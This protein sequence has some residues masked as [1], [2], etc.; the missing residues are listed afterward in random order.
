MTFTAAPPRA[1]LHKFVVALL[2]GGLGRLFVLNAPLL[3][4][5][6][7]LR[8]D[9]AVA[10]FSALA[11]GPWFGAVSSL[12]ATAGT[13]SPI[14]TAIWAVEPLFVVPVVG[15]G[16][17]PV[18]AVAGYWLTVGVTVSSGLLQLPAVGV[19]FAL[20]VARQ[21]VNG[22]LSAVL[23]QAALAFDGVRQLFGAP[24]IGGPSAPL[25]TQIARAL[26]PVST[27]PV[28][29][30]GLGLGRMYA[31]QLVLE[32]T[33]DLT[34]AAETSALR[35]ADY[36]GAA[37]GDVRT[38]AGQ[39]S[40]GGSATLALDDTLNLHHS[41]STTFLTMLVSDA[42]GRVL[43]QSTRLDSAEPRSVP[44]PADID[45]REYFSAPAATGRPFRS[46]GFRGRAFGG[47][48][49]VVLSAPYTDANGQFAGIAQGALNLVAFGDWLQQFLPM[50]G[51]SV[52]VLDRTGQVIAS[53]GPASQ[54][55]LSDGRALPW[56]E[57]TASQRVGYFAEGTAPTPGAPQPRQV[58][59]R[60]DV[61]GLGWQVYVRRP[62][63]AMQGPLASFYVLTAGWLLF[64]L[65]I[66]T[67]IANRVSQHITQPLEVLARRAEAVGRS[68]IAAPEDL[69]E[70]A[71]AE[72]K[73]LERELSAMVSRL[74]ESVRLLDQKVR[75][76]TAELSAATARNDTIFRAASDG[77]VV[78]DAERRVIEANDAFCHLVGLP[79]AQVL[80]RFMRDFELGATDDLRQQ[81]EADHART[82]TSRFETAMRTE[83]GDAVPVEVVVT[84]MPG[85]G[86][87]VFAGVRDISDRRRAETERAQLE[88]RLRQSQKMEA[89]G[90]LAGGIAHDF[91]NILTLITGSADLAAVDVPEGHP[92]R[93]YL[94]Q[95]VR[96]SSRAEALV[97]QILTFSRRRDEQREVVALGPIVREAVDILR[98]T[99]PAMIDIRVQVDERVPAVQADPVQLHQVLMNLGSN[100]AHAMRD[101]GGQLAITLTPTGDGRNAVLAVSDTGTGMDRATLERVFEPFFTTKPVGA[102]TGLG[103]AVVHGIVTGHGG[104]IDVSSEAGRGTTFRITLPGAGHD[105][106][107]T[108][109]TE[110]PL[111]EPEPSHRSAHVLVVDDE[112]ELVG[113]LC[114]QLTR[115]GYTA[116]GCAGPSEALDR[117][118]AGGPSIDVV[119]SD[120]AM[121]KMSGI[122]L[123]EVIHHERPNLP[124][125]LCSGR[126][127][128]E[129]RVRAQ[130]AGVSEFLAKPFGSRQLATAM[131]RS[132]GATGTRH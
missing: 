40:R 70:S 41:G 108:A 128:D 62:I 15:Y 61:A 101:T 11:L 53:T 91:N 105:V 85:G 44:P 29:L 27:I 37:E 16:V 129:D 23:A 21:L 46:E 96:A 26:V 87:R 45:D 34:T 9:E 99:L 84:N 79:H 76:R 109:S 4:D 110:H 63:A 43:S 12:V 123:A 104:N 116:Q 95:I 8:L 31:E 77:M 118:R 25:R 97:R 22:T 64:C 56:V 55:L 52:L 36:V 89:I 92:A 71:P 14:F 3:A 114:R 73:L 120:L 86:N 98:S 75:E 131:A 50:S 19:G 80:G 65:A 78:L 127:T 93:Q 90:T 74:D 54:P 94:E 103:L 82:G 68:H 117:L 38:L 121:P 42:R 106:A 30:L 126:V 51:A 125:V 67:L 49:I 115:L 10:L 69:A 100:A 1:P 20:V 59:V 6:L 122:E 66:A 5:G 102:G 18:I 111:G 13:G 132:L 33:S 57:A 17:P 81:R 39:L 72:V 28:I 35:L 83:A 88:S 60:Q 32:G 48:P 58:A 119:V 47:N 2:L 107:R 124:I 130:Q 112:P 7:L 113:L 24:V